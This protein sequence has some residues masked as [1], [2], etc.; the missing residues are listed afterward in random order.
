ME[1]RRRKGGRRGGGRRGGGRREGRSI[2]RKER[3]KIR[4]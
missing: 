4:C 2:L 1:G 3:R